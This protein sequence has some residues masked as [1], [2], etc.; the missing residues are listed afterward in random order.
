[1][2]DL[3]NRLELAHADTLVEV[4][5]LKKW[6][7]VQTTFLD[8]VFSRGNQ[9]VRA[10]DG[11]SF[12]IRRGEVFGLAGE[13]GSGKTT[14]GRAVLRLTEPTAGTVH[15]SGIDLQT[16]D[17][18]RMR[19]MRRWMQVIFQEPMASLNPRMSL[20]ESISQGLGIHFPESAAEHRKV[21]FEIMQ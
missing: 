16:L 9:F 7:P 11:V 18:R 13:S 6:Y 2:I 15:F 3:D 8:K 21:T 4:R 12:D 19:E 17:S 10:V 14:T 20:G 1:M 5:D